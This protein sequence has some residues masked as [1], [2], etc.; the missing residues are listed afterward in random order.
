[1]V[2]ESGA[3]LLRTKSGCDF[4]SKI[5]RGQDMLRD[6]I[7]WCMVLVEVCLAPLTSLIFWYPSSS[8]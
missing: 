7:S 2:V 5:P 3:C 8:S 6:F 1:M 4:W